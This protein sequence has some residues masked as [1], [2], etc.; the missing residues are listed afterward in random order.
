M[1]TIPLT[2]PG[3]FVPILMSMIAI[4]MVAG[5]ALIYGTTS[6]ADE[7]TAAHIFQLLI[8]LQI[9]IIVL[10]AVKWL[11]KEPRAAAWSLLVQIALI[12]IACAVVYGLT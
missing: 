1:K 4:A 3:V 7:G 10:F 11:P 2:R 5:H 6:E 8:I 9:P 12:A